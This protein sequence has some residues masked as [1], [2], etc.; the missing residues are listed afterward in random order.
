MA[1]QLRAAA[2]H[3]E[4]MADH[5]CVLDSA[6]NME[7]DYADLVTSDPEVAEMFSMIPDHWH[8]EDC[9]SEQPGEHLDG[10]SLTDLD[11]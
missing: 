10:C 8:C 2:S 3:L 5:G 4:N 6:D 9:G 7:D 11:E 1:E